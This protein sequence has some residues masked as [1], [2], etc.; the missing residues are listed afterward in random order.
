MDHAFLLQSV[1]HFQSSKNI[2]EPTM[3]TAPQIDEPQTLTGL[4]PPDDD[5]DDNSDDDGEPQQN[6]NC[7]EVQSVKLAGMDLQIRQFDYHSHNANRVWPG[8]FHLAEYL[9]LE[10][11]KTTTETATLC[12]NHGHNQTTTTTTS[13]TRRYQHHWGRVLELGT[14]T[15][16]LAIRMAL[17]SEVV[18]YYH[19]NH[20]QQ[21][22][23]KGCCC[24]SVV[25]TDVLVEDEEDQIAANLQHNYRINGLGVMDDD[26]DKQQQQHAP[27]TTTTTTRR[28]RRRRLL[29]PP[30]VPHTWGTGWKKSVEQSGINLDSMDP[31][32]YQLLPQQQPSSS[33][34]ASSSFDTIIASDILLY[35]SAYPALVQTLTELIPPHCPTVL[36]M[37]WNRRMKESAEFFERMG[38]AGFDRQHCGKGIYTMRRRK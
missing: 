12:C 22:S 17:A 10:E 34:S 23:D 30:H 7:Y 19:H 35:V 2:R 31:R 28:R 16:L 26:D 18:Y 27:T 13:R 37:S 21:Q 14:A 20:H 15:G 36:V 29:P 24:T 32:F 4:F 25:T 8:T 33:S 38:N 9:L 11:E 1:S 6:D 3:P 5:D